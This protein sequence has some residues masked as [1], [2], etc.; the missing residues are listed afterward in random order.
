MDLP[1]GAEGA[2]RLYVERFT[3]R[4][5]SEQMGEEQVQLL[6]SPEADPTGDGFGFGDSPWGETKL[7]VSSGGE[8][9]TLD[10]ILSRPYGEKGWKAVIYSFMDAEKSCVVVGEVTLPQE[11]GRLSVC[12]D[13]E[14]I[15]STSILFVEERGEAGIEDA[16]ERIWVMGGHLITTLNEVGDSRRASWEVNAQFA[17]RAL[18]LVAAAVGVNGPQGLIDLIWVNY[19]IDE[20]LAGASRLPPGASAVLA[21]IHGVAL[22]VLELEPLNALSGVIGGW[23]AA[24]EILQATVWGVGQDI[25]RVSPSHAEE[26]MGALGTTVKSF[27]EDFMKGGEQFLSNLAVVAKAGKENKNLLN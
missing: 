10:V 2:A 5:E 25:R 7:T 27:R 23:C 15:A 17:R 20:A 8:T 11:D 14:E 24:A 21:P 6:C 9:V 19:G 1:A 3:A 12:F 13:G 26:F 16:L 22:K 18:G 4:I